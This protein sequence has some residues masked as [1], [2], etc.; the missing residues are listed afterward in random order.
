MVLGHQR[1]DC[2]DESTDR[3]HGPSVGGGELLGQCVK[4][5][6]PQACAVEQHH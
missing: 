5:A 3:V 6:E 1:S 2:V 4:R